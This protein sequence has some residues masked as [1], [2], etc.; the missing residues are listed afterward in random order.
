M[1]ENEFFKYKTFDEPKRQK[2][3]FFVICHN[4]NLNP[5]SGEFGL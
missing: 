1:N 5:D 2:E 3:P 4:P